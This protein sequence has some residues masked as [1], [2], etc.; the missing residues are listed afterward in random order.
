[1]TSTAD[2]GPQLELTEEFT[3]AL[4][5]LHRGSHLYLTGKAGTG[6]STLIKL[7]T[8]ATKRN[9]VVA[10]PTGIAA[11]NVDG[12]TLH[13][14]FSFHPSRTTLEQVRFGNY[15]PGRFTDVIANLETL[16]IDEISMVRAD[17]FDMIAAALER[18]GPRPGTPFGGVQLVLVGDLYQLA[19]VVTEGEAAELSRLYETPF[20]FSADSYDPTRFP[21]VELTKVFR[22]A[23]DQKLVTLLNAVREGLLHDDDRAELN[24]K[25]DPAF[26]PPID[27]FWLTLATTNRIA[28]ARNN[29]SLAQL[30]GQLY[31]SEAEVSGSM[32]EKDP[33]VPLQLSLKVGAQVM[34]LNNDARGRWVN[35]TI[36]QICDI[37]QGPEGLRVM[38]QLPDGRRE[39]VEPHTWEI[40]QPAST[41]TG[42]KRE[43]IGSI[44]QLPMQ[45]AWAITIHKSQGQTLERVHLD[46]SGG[47]FADGQLYVALS[48]CTSLDGLVLKREIQ[49]RDLKVDNRVR[50]FMLTGGT[51]TTN[52]GAVYLAA[53]LVGDDGRMWRKR[54]IEL[55]AVSDDGL[56]LT[57]LIDPT[58]D[59]GDA[60]TEFGIG[61][62]DVQLA[63][64]LDQAW[65]L[66]AEVF[67]GYVPVA[68]GVDQLLG[69]IDYEL[70][71]HHVVAQLPMGV[72]APHSYHPAPT[73]VSA[74]EKARELAAVATR[75]G[76]RTDG[77]ESLIPV[78]D[79]TGFLRP[80]G[81]DA[82]KFCILETSPETP[83][84][85]ADQLRQAVKDRALTRRN[86]QIVQR[87]EELLGAS[88]L[89]AAA[90]GASAESS[91]E[92]VLVPRARVCFTGSAVDLD[93]EEITRSA[94]EEKARERGLEPVNSVTKSKCEALLSA[95]TGSMST[96]ARNAAKWGK[97]IFT[98]EEFLSWFHGR[99]SQTADVEKAEL[100]VL[101][102]PIRIAPALPQANKQVPAQPAPSPRRDIQP[103]VAKPQPTHVGSHPGESR[104]APPLQPPTTPQTHPAVGGPW[105][106]SMPEYRPVT[107][108]SQHP[109]AVPYPHQPHPMP[110]QPFRPVALL[111]NVRFNL[112]ML[113]IF[114]GFFVGGFLIF[115]VG[116]VVPP[117]A[118][119]AGFL[120]FFGFLFIPLW[121]TLALV[122]NSKLKKF[123][124]LGQPILPRG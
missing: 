85:L 78:A 122:H 9:I 36:C 37:S 60:K 6:K 8:E 115:M 43:R 97:P 77:Q 124:R 89:P 13:R 87:L 76:L 81:E 27:E 88:I 49:P 53:N 96:K 24:T 7:F 15:S 28:Q 65:P 4:E 82:E 103:P 83:S 84:G 118:I 34:M 25:L 19:P 111:S 120:W 107:A 21:T 50:R 32:L 91:I 42:I 123:G 54:P 71:R 98:V 95:E 94:L 113:W 61:A 106:Q 18:F 1:M 108:P 47:T 68:R 30:P 56:E 67:A 5:L 116:F 121:L 12:Y 57:T 52:R 69:Y 99:S 73:A 48:R 104:T 20:F 86:T 40:T 59:I 119:V 2:T 31:V 41:G 80:R 74:L 109:V 51:Q 93:G 62:E 11:L 29:E 64:T 70:K 3:T 66:F 102:E 33:P 44:R 26:T 105:R 16:I 112:R 58:R 17:L 75:A 14:L 117:I 39:A 63:P 10:A 72:E 35:G 22:Q 100:T 55:A 92:E 114:L 79:R 23:G 46:L 101:I 110:G 45:L 90:G 38:I